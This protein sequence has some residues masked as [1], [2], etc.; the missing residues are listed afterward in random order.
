MLG[1]QADGLAHPSTGIHAHAL[2]ARWRVAR[3]L[4]V[5]DKKDGEIVGGGTYEV[6]ADGRTLTVSS[7]RGEQVIVLERS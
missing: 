1:V 7:A 6:S 4:E 2:V 3:V 5:R